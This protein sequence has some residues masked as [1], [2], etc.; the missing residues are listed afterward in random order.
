MNKNDILKASLIIQ[1]GGLV[2]FPTET[3]YGLG[4]NALDPLAVARIFEAKKR[5]FFD[6]LIVHVE[7][8][9]TVEELATEIPAIAYQLIEKFW[10]GPLTIILKK[11]DIVPDIVTAGFDTIAVRMP[12]HPIALELI[13]QSGCPIAAPS[14][15]PFG[16][17]SPTQAK[18]VEKYL[19]QSVDM[20][21]DGGKCHQGLEST[22]IDVTNSTPF[23]LRAGALPI[24][25]IQRIAKNAQVISG[26]QDITTPGSLPRHYAPNTKL[27]LLKRNDHFPSPKKGIGYLTFGPKESFLEDWS[28]VCSLSNT[29]NLTEAATNLFECLHRLDEMNLNV[30][31][32]K[33]LPDVGLG[34]AIM[35]RLTKAANTFLKK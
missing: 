24:E 17:L 8:I 22:I 20:I 28:N 33:E 19:G 5:P 35:D 4:A 25:D 3:V 15:N 31:Y 1:K 14:A 9:K 30:I 34:I 16:Q 27:I 6:P 23:I 7:N 32:V 29:G 11:K 2:A 12:N 10:P 13:K 21:L 26:K 18:H